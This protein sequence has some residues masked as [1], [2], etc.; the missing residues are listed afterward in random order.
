MFAI[1]PKLGSRGERDCWGAP[2]EPDPEHGAAD[3][4]K[5]ERCTTCNRILSNPMAGPRCVGF[6]CEEER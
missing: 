1:K 3:G 4:I 5:L 6:Y 2:V